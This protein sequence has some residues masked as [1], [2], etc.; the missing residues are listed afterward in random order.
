MHP[1]KRALKEKME[2]YRKHN[3]NSLQNLK[4]FRIIP[5]K[6]R[7]LTIVLSL[8][9]ISIAGV[10]SVSYYKAK[11]NQLSLMEDRL[12]R[13]IN[14]MQDLAQKMKFAYIGDDILFQK[15]LYKGIN[16][17]KSALQLDDLSPE[18]YVVRENEVVR[19]ET[20]Q[21][22]SDE[23]DQGLAS[24]ILTREDGAFIR[25]YNG[26]S[27]LFSVGYIAELQGYYTVAI[28]ESDYI[29]TARQMAV[30]TAT[31]GLI[32][33]IIIVLTVSFFV[34]KLTRPITDLQSEMKKARNGDFQNVEQVRSSTPEIH[35]LNNSFHN[36]ISQIN[37]LFHNIDHAI[38]QLTETGDQLSVSSDE[39]ADAQERMKHHL[40]QV[41]HDANDTKETL[42]HYGDVVT[43][44]TELI[45]LLNGVFRDLKNRQLQ[46]NQ[47]V[48][49][50]NEGVSS[51]LSALENFYQGI[52]EMGK[53]IDAF[54]EHTYNIQK[55]G[56][57]IQDIA[58]RTKLLALN[59]SIEAARAG[60]SGQGF[61]VVAGEIKKLAENSRSAAD[62]IHQKLNET[63]EISHFLA[64][65]FEGFTSD[66]NEQFKT[67]HHSKQIFEDLKGHIEEINHYIEKS[68]QEMNRTEDMVPELKKAFHIFSTVTNNTVESI[69]QLYETANE[70]KEK[71]KETEE[72][73]IQL[74]ALSQSLAT[75]IP[76]QQEK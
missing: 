15:E 27:W 23:F 55:S 64:A 75:L 3:F 61:A 70:Q 54:E 1:V 68:E 16:Q 4:F 34:S 8:F 63:I 36:L 33:I 17:Q 57:I 20:N 52:Q 10:G 39:L 32:S 31:V 12:N 45:H 24:D 22:T 46:M 25:E 29:Q 62:E 38:H 35:S 41:I 51:I 73:R 44:V 19:F 69:H 50:G 6:W 59:A 30:F 76:K 37:T 53:K 58:E 47:S 13:E 42:S 40:M 48:E 60:E 9:A 43:S 18:I 5:L 65:R 14:V 26:Q 11:E 21:F 56:S 74:F 7:L 2:N 66:L 72:M 49:K 71:M 28:P 67:I